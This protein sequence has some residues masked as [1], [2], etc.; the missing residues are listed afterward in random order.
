MNQ[1][2]IG[3]IFSLGAVLCCL[4][5]AQTPI[6]PPSTSVGG[7]IFSQDPHSSRGFGT[8][9]ARVDS[10]ITLNIP[11]GQAA[12]VY[13]YL[14]SAYA[15]NNDLLRREFP[16]FP[17]HGDK[18]IDVSVFTDRYFDTPNLDL[19][20]S[21]NSARYRTRINTT[22]KADPKS[23]R[24]L[25]QVKVT[26]PAGFA[27]RTELKFAVK[28]SKRPHN[29][30]DLHPLIS[31]IDR[32]QR[33]DF[34]D[35]IEQLGLNPLTLQRTLTIQQQRSR[36]YIYWGEENILSFSVDEY[37]AR[38]LWTTA[39][40]ASVDVGLVENVFTEANE[41]KRKKMQEIRDFMVRDLKAHFPKMEQASQEKYCI[42]LEQ[43]MAKLPFFRFLLKH[44][45]I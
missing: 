7:A 21:Q 34:K 39:R 6:P 16:A 40:S 30:D 36:V 28:P 11:D 29:V 32:T 20:Q 23:G 35:A 17:L 4:G 5:R 24:E 42:L 31:R 25:V 41:N 44:R 26:P 13:A 33:Q 43:I 2:R 19:F 14:R 27:M 9:A 18:K 22:N 10:Q 3:A 12:A 1:I 8:E 37:Q 45:L 38:T 15:E